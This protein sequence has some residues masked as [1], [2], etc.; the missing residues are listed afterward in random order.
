[1]NTIPAAA[2]ELIAGISP[3]RSAA[4]TLGWAASQGE[5]PSAVIARISSLRASRS[6]KT[7]SSDSAMPVIELPSTMPAIGMT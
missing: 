1:M 3:A 6:A 7:R 4:R 5:A 2:I